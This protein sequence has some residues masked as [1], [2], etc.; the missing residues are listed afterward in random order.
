MIIQEKKER[1]SEKLGGTVDETSTILITRPTVWEMKPTAV[2]ANDTFDKASERRSK[3]ARNDI[4]A[5]KYRTMVTM[6]Q[7]AA[8]GNTPAMTR[9]RASTR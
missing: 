2:I 8:I 1:A 7:T 5:T 4:V 9:D 6:K 3:Y